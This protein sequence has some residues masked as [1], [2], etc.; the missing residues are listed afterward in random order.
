MISV[1]RSRK[2]DP[3]WLSV[4]APARLH[5]GFVD[6]NGS[7][8][9]R[10]GSLGLALEQPATQIVLRLAGQTSASGPDSARALQYARTLLAQFGQTAGVE[11]M[12]EQIIP[13]HAGLGSGTQLALAVGSGITRLLELPLST[14]E[15][16]ARL[17]RGAR[18]G[19]GIGAF[20][21]GGFLVD[22]G[23]GDATRVP[24]LIT[25]LAF[26]EDW[27]VLLIFDER[28]QGVHG[29]AEHQAFAELPE[30]SDERAGELCRLLL[31]QALPA[32]AE[33]DI[34][35]FGEAI[36]RIQQHIGSYFAPLQ[37]GE[38]FTSPAVAA[39]LA[40]LTRHGAHGVGQSSWGPTGFAFVADERQGRQLLAALRKHHHHASYLR[41]ILGK[42]RNGPAEMTTTPGTYAI[43]RVGE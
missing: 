20:D 1:N 5:L 7:L 34:G 2:T 40:W 43:S 21:Q 26:P 39:A 22:G 25:R 3:G 35:A 32:L 17:Q 33:A 4:T 31:M 24:P 27:R 36:S 13:S 9:R 19:I 14:A 12:V 8:G 15:I 38:R 23:R 16:A 10:F 18:S 30:F 37:G 29:E 11:I 42:P 28:E 41:F 6:L